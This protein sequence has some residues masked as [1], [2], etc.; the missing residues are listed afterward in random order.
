MLVGL[1][2]SKIH[3]SRCESLAADCVHSE[4][5]LARE[6]ERWGVVI[7]YREIPLC[8]SRRR[9]RRGAAGAPVARALATR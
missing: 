3:A 2:H 6:D 1:V 8:R 7:E 9:L 4:R 5:V